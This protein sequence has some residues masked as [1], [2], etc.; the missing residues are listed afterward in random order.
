L[1]KFVKT[2][3]RKLDMVFQEIYSSMKVTRY[4][5]PGSIK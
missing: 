4:F 1:T 2:D 5:R 3:I